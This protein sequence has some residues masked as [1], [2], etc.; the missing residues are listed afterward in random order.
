MTSP[1]ES[2]VRDMLINPYYAITFADSVFNTKKQEVAK[3]DW[4][5]QTPNL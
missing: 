5:L 4:V 3:E 2:N 1:D